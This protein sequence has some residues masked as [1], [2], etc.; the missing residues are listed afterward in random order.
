MEGGRRVE[1]SRESRRM[2]ESCVCMYKD[3]GLGSG[4]LGLCWGRVGSRGLTRDL[5]FFF[6]VW[7]LMCTSVW[8]CARR[9][10]ALYVVFLLALTAALSVLLL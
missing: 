10:D 8:V 7:I 5:C 4:G 2:D 6:C 3:C 1:V 9:R